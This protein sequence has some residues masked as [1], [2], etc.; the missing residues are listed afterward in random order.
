MDW[1]PRVVFVRHRRA[2]RYIMR[3]LADGT[4]RVTLPRWGTRREA[5]AFVEANTA[6]VQDQRARRRATVA[7]AAPTSELRPLIAQW[8]RRKA[9]RE[10][11]AMLMK[12]ATAYDIHVARV[13]VRDQQSRWGA[14]SSQ[15]TITLNWRLIQVPDFVREYVMLHELMHRRELNHSRRFWRLVAACCPRHLEA[16][17][18]LK[19]EG[20]LL[21][22][23]HG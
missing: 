15:G 14:C 4:L 10:L 11:P 6:W 16:R 1:P 5:Q 9:A 2:R 20:K 7:R 23:D 13:S 8:Y 22:P 21:W 19:R 18:W 3:V 17:R 12:L